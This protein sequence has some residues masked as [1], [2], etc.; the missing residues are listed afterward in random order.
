[1]II[2][3]EKATPPPNKKR[4]LCRITYYW[5]GED[6]G[7][8]NYLGVQDL[9][10]SKGSMAADLDFIPLRTK[11]YTEYKYPWGNE[12]EV[13]DTGTALKTRKAAILS[14]KNPIERNA[15]VLD[16]FVPSKKQAEEFIK[17]YPHYM[18]IYY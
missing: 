2:P 18:W 1:M 11:V 13:R 4:Q 7:T 3:L 5:P 6:S 9:K 12:F 8:T 17:I 10:L 16:I 14:G 15:P